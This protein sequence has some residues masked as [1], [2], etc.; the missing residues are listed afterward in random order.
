MK[1]EIEDCWKDVLI[2][3]RIEVVEADGLTETERNW[4]SRGIN[5]SVG[6]IAK[7]I[8]WTKDKAVRL[9]IGQTA[10]RAAGELNVGG[11]F[12]EMGNDDRM[13]AYIFG[14]T[15][16]PS[17]INKWKPETFTMPDIV[18]D[19]YISK[20]GDYTIKREY[21]VHYCKETASS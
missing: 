12:L 8:S 17:S 5:W 3:S 9:F 18:A 15:C 6:R 19:D 11:Y 20:V 14:P 4:L 2:A 16:L 13:F 21:T 1:V 7:A 10:G